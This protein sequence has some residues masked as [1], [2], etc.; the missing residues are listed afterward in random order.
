MSSAIGPVEWIIILI[1]MLMGGLLPI[2]SLVLTLLIYLKVK[3]I[4]EILVVL[5]L[6]R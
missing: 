2:G 4:E 3:K 1:I 5:S 6:R